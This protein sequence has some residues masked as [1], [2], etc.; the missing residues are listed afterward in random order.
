MAGPSYVLGRFYTA[1][2]PPSGASVR[3]PCSV[4]AGPRRLA[5][6]HS[7]QS[8]PKLWSGLHDHNDGHDDDDDIVR[9]RAMA[10]W[11]KKTFF[12]LLSNFATLFLKGAAIMLSRSS[13]VLGDW[14]KDNN[15]KGMRIRMMMIWW[16]CDDRDDDDD[17]DDDCDD[18]SRV[19]PADT[20]ASCT[21]NT[22][23]TTAGALYMQALF[24]NKVRN[25]KQILSFIHASHK[26]TDFRILV[27]R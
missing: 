21:N 5:C 7:A 20:T 12:F 8:C 17:D 10:I 16:Q 3:L 9:I 18:E 4:T 22:K 26:H 27:L 23:P 19:C 25:K 24:W 14:N 1:G 2:L 15:D 6:T 11:G 13:F